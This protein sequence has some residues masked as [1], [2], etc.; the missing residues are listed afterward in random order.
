MNVHRKRRIHLCLFL[1]RQKSLWMNVSMCIF[2]VSPVVC[3]GIV[4][5]RQYFLVSKPF[6]TQV[7]FNF[8]ISNDH[9][10]NSRHSGHLD[11]VKSTLIILKRTG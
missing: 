3:L 9:G 8:E 7:I 4:S 5:L 1:S 6:N 10:T 11:P 2:Q